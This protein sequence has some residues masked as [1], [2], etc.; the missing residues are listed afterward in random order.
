MRHSDTSKFKILALIA[1]AFKSASAMGGQVESCNTSGNQCIVSSR[2][3]ITGDRVGLFSSDDRLVAYGR[4]KKMAGTRR[5]VSIDKAYSSV[6]GGERVA[7]LNNVTDPTS[8]EELYTVQ[9][10]KGRTIIDMTVAT[11]S[12][13]IGPGAPGIETTAAYIKRSWQDIEL[14]GRAMFTTVS[15]EGSQAY[16]LRDYLGKE[17]RGID[18]QSFGANVYGGLAGLGYTLYG[19]SRV[20]FRGEVDTGVAYVAGVV[21]EGDMTNSSG[22]P[23]KLENGFGLVVRGAA[24]AMVN[25]A[26]WHVGLTLGQTTIQDASAATFGLSLSKSLE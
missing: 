18:V 23:T 10:N 4:V 14:T 5:V 19:T 20:S 3:L 15:G 2:E 12:Y 1:L 25:I 26:T 22:F 7:L 17:T 24:T 16:V 8:I 21:G 6:S 9:R 13:S 11:A